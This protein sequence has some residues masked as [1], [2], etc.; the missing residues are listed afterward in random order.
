MIS[1][2]WFISWDS[3]GSSG[4]RL[5]T[6]SGDLSQQLMAIVNSKDPV[7]ITEIVDISSQK[8][9]VTYMRKLSAEGRK[10]FRSKMT[11]VPDGQGLGP[12]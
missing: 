10:I 2:T 9:A 3:L 4:E 1:K 6:Y 7:S 8:D 5:G 11:H 12:E